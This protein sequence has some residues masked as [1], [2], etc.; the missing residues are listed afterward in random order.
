[1]GDVDG[2]RAATAYASLFGA[3]D[4]WG[5]LAAASRAGGAAPG[6]PTGSAAAP[7]ACGACGG[8]MRRKPGAGGHVCDD[9]A[10]VAG[11]DAAE[12]ADD[13][14]DA[15][16]APAAGAQLRV[17]GPRASQLQ[18]DL[19]RSG[20]G[21]TAATQKKAIQDEYRAYRQLYAEAGGAVVPLDACDAAADLYG[22]VQRQCVKRSL[23]KRSAMAAC[24]QIASLSLQFAP[25]K[26]DLAAMMQLPSRGI[27]RGANFVRALVADGKMDADVN[28][29]P[30]VPE[31]MSLFAHL[32]YEGAAYAGLRAAALDVVTTAVANNICTGSILRSKVA[33]ATYVVLRRCTDRA[34][35]AAPPGPKEFCQ[36]RIRKNTYERVTRQ[37]DEYHSFFVP[38]YRRAGLDDSPPP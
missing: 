21:T 34:L 35:V 33:G 14:D 22:D 12:P 16:R 8:V 36:D 27:A 24:L 2:L 7:A 20:A 19:F 3:S 10:L 25:A 28:I 4:L 6:G 29:D 23:N 37:I 5:A 1:M 26:A 38:C 17:V 11:G 9:C 15:P 32:G 18:P 30:S 13:D 31:I